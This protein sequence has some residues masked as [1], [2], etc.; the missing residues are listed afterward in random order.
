MANQQPIAISPRRANCYEEECAEA[1]IER[2]KHDASSARPAAVQ[3][4]KFGRVPHRKSH[5]CQR[6]VISSVQLLR[7]VR[8]LEAHFGRSDFLRFGFC[9]LGGFVGQ[10]ERVEHALEPLG[11]SAKYSPDTSLLFFGERYVA[12]LGRPQSEPGYARIV[13]ERSERESNAPSNCFQVTHNRCNYVR[14]LRGI[15]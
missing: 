15:K 7:V 13:R 8:Y 4:L 6:R 14:C 2:T 5:R 10:V 3:L 11:L 12:S 9:Q 1:T